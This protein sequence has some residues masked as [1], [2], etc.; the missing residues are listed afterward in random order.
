MGR[1]KKSFSEQ[2]GQTILYSQDGFCKY[3]YKFKEKIARFSLTNRVIILLPFS[4]L[5]RSGNSNVTRWHKHG[6]LYFAK[7]GE[8]L[9]VWM[10][11]TKRG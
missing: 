1:G 5:I 3:V 8:E 4:T 11:T 9:K 10:K 6:L 2:K 7:M